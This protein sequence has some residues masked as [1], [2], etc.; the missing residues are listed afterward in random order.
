MCPKCGYTGAPIRCEHV[1][2]CPRC[3]AVIPRKG[4][5]I[6]WPEGLLCPNCNEVGEP[7]PAESRMYH[8]PKCRL[9][10]DTDTKYRCR[11]EKIKMEEIAPL[12]D[13]EL[14]RL[15]TYKSAFEAGYY[16][17]K[18]QQSNDVEFF[19]RLIDGT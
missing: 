11:P 10:W 4:Q 6:D 17:D 7:H 3:R 18:E 13:K 2:V 14:Q 9:L 15:K 5:T 8:C 1:A 12:T 19:K 16:S